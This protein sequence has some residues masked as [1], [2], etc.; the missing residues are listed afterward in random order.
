LEYPEIAAMLNQI[1][2]SVFMDAQI[3]GGK[4]K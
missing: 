3:E 1:I 2:A 4:K